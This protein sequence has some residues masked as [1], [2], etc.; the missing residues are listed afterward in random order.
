VNDRRWAELLQDYSEDA[1]LERLIFAG[2]C[3]TIVISPTLSSFHYKPSVPA[4]RGS[5]ALSRQRHRVH[6]P[7]TL[8]AVSTPIGHARHTGDEQR[9]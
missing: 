7:I 5:T 9:W 6:R 4:F 3:R 8:L 2:D 1:M